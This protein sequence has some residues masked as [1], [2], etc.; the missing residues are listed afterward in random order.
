[1]TLLDLSS[2]STTTAALELEP[3][4][5]GFGANV[6]G[7]DPGDGHPAAGESLYRLYSR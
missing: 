4:G 1:M 2:A 5:P 3:L 7:L 6:H